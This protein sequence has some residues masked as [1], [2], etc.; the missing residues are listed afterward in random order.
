MLSSL[1]STSFLCCVVAIY[2]FPSNW[3]HYSCRKMVGYVHRL[4]PPFLYF[5][6]HL[7]LKMFCQMKT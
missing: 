2:L 5:N 6:D 7:T 4:V 1:L 3:W